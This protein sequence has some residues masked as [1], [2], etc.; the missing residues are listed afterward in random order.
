MFL[1]FSDLGHPP[2]TRGDPRSGGSR[3][4]TDFG[5]RRGPGTG[6]VV[7]SQVV[8]GQ[9]RVLPIHA[10]EGAQH[11]DLSGRRHQRR[12]KSFNYFH[13]DRC[14]RSASPFFLLPVPPIRTHFQSFKAERFRFSI[15]YSALDVNEFELKAE[16]CFHSEQV[17]KFPDKLNIIYSNRSLFFKKSR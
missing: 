13:A 11:A 14:S 12:R 7:L 10:Q 8:Q 16:T 5:V 1:W 3:R 4:V 9:R 2:G 17:L 15:Q 6:R